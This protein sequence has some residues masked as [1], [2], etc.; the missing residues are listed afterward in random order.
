DG[1]RHLTDAGYGGA[2][3]RVLQVQVGQADTGEAVQR[4]FQHGCECGDGCESWSGQPSG[5]DLVE[6]LGRDRRRVRDL[7][8]LAVTPFLTQVGAQTLAGGD[9]LRRQRGSHHANRIRHVGMKIPILP[10]LWYFYTGWWRG[11]VEG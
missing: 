5:L 2:L 10:L 8:G 7:G 3:P 1:C 6:G 9:L 4:D 11:C